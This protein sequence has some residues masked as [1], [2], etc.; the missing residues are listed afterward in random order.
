[1]ELAVGIGVKVGL[2]VEVMVGVGL[3]YQRKVA[4][5]VRVG[6]ITGEGVINTSGG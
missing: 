4:V 2:I 1:V 3:T 5:G 6:G